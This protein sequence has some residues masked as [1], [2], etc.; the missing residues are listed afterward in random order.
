MSFLQFIAISISWLVSTN[1]NNRENTAGKG[2]QVIQKMHL[3][4]T[5]IFKRKAVAT[6]PFFLCLFFQI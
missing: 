3:Q 6:V 1:R 5:D 4:H 2:S